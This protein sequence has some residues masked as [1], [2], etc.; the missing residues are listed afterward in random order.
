MM[1]KDE[2]ISTKKQDKESS[3]AKGLAYGA[4]G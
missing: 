1:Q 4:K 2:H 3:G